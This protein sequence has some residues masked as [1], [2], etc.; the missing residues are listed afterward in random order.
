MAFPKFFLVEANSSS[1]WA[2]LLS[3]S[4][5]T[6]VNSR[7]A[8]RTLFSSCSRAPSA[9]EE[10]ASSSIF[11]ASSL[12]DFVNL[13]DGAPTL[14]DLVHD[15]LDLVGEQLI[16]SADFLQ[17]DDGF[18][19]GI[20]HLEQFRGDVAGFFLSCAQVH[21]ETVHFA[22]PFPNN[23]IKLLGL[24]LHGRVHYLGLV[25]LLGHVGRISSSL[26]LG[27]L[28]L[29]K[30]ELQLLDHG[31]ALRQPR[32]HLQ[33]CHLELLSLGNAVNLIFLLPHVRIAQCLIELPSQ[34]LLGAHLLV[35]VL[36]Q[37]IGHVLHVSELSK[38]ADSLLSLVV[39]N[40]LLLIKSR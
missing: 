35:V 36:L 9:S 6:W 37:A 3:I 11:S 14:A 12:P 19:V 25:Q 21:A 39:G 23:P 32:L 33:L 24:L 7:E 29:C 40:G 30:L 22:L 2:I 27:L 10:A 28:H 38:K 34:V 16:F 13:V 26:G 4:C 20:L 1:F 8:R 31:R 17:L 5:L 18:V 15:V